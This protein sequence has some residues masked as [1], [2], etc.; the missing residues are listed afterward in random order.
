MLPQPAIAS[1]ATLLY[2]FA[3]Y[4]E[5]ILYGE[6]FLPSSEALC[7]HGEEHHDALVRFFARGKTIVAIALQPVE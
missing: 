2:S 4:L 1:D 5:L 7:E 3:K 6:R